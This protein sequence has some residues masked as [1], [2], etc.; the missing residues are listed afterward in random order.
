MKAWNPWHGCH[1]ISPGCK[2]CYMHRRDESIGKD[3]DTVYR[4]TMFDLPLKKKRDG[5]F[6]LQQKGDVFTCGT[7][8]FFLEEADEWRTEAWGMIRQRQDLS[9]LIITKRIYR[10]YEKLP[11]DWGEGYP[12]VK[13]G[14]TVENQEQANY[15]IPIFLKTP[16]RHKIIIC[17]PILERI[18]LTPFLSGQIEMVVA[19]GESGYYARICEFDWILEIE[20]ECRKRNISFWFKQTGTHFKKDGKRYV[21]RKRFQHSQARKAG[22]NYSATK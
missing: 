22:I 13:I 11:P 4:T 21:I 6:R 5:N 8:D 10:F 20:R 3:P 16:I 9:F 12:N 7:S 14:C 17:E 15:R 1:K 18:D 2:N 19:G